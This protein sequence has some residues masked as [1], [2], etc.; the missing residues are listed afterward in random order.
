MS[1]EINFIKLLI[2]S[3]FIEFKIILQQCDIWVALRNSNAD[4]AL[5]EIFHKIN[6]KINAHLAY[7]I[8]NA[9]WARPGKFMPAFRR[10]P[11]FA[12]ITF[13]GQLAVSNQ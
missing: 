10:A 5:L 9:L 1:Q 8:A 7:A 3:I 12:C 11:L 4:D 2:V 13:P 6:I